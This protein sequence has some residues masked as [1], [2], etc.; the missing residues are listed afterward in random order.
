MSSSDRSSVS[1]TLGRGGPLRGQVLGER[2]EI[3]AQLRHDVYSLGLLAFDQET[4]SRVVLRVLRPQILEHGRSRAFHALRKSVGIG[5]RYLPGLLDADLDGELLFAVEPVPEGAPLRDVLDARIAAQRP[6]RAEELLVLVGHLEAALSAIPPPLRHGDVRADHVWVDP[7]RLRLMGSFLVPCL[8]QP[9]VSHLLQNDSGVRRRTAPEALRGS[10]SDAADRF[11]IGAIVCEALTLET[12]PAAG[13]TGNLPPTPVGEEVRRLL[14]ADPAHRP[15]SLDPLLD[16]L[17]RESG[18]AVPDLDPAPMRAARRMS[19]PRADSFAPVGGST[20]LRS[21]PSS[22]PPIS[23]AAKA[24][25]SVPAARGGSL[26][27]AE[28]SAA[29]SGSDDVETTNGSDAS[30]DFAFDA[31]TAVE[32]RPVAP[33]ARLEDDRLPPGPE[34]SQEASTRRISVTTLDVSTTSPVTPISKRRAAKVLEDASNR[35]EDSAAETAGPQRKRKGRMD[36]EA[37]SND[38]SSVEFED[39]RTPSSERAGAHGLDPRFVRAALTRE[40]QKPSADDADSDSDVERDPSVAVMPKTDGTQELRLDDLELAQDSEPPLD[41]SVSAT[42]DEN[43]TQQVR[44]YELEPADDVVYGDGETDAHGVDAHGV[45]AHGVDAHGVDAH[46]V[47]A[48]GVDA[49]G[50]DAHGVDAHG[51]DAHGIEAHGVDAHGVDAH[52]I[53]ALGEDFVEPDPAIPV[54]P[55]ADG[56]QELRMEDLELHMQGGEQMAMHA[57][58][59]PARDVTLD[60]L[61]QMRS[62]QEAL[63]AHRPSGG[64]H[65]NPGW[66][67][68][69]PA[70]TAPLHGIQAIP[71][72]RQDSLVGARGPI[73]FDDSGTAPP[74]SSSNPHGGTHPDESLSATN[75][76]GPYSHPTPPSQLRA[77]QVSAHSTTHGR[78]RSAAIILAALLLGAAFILGS[79]A[80]S[81]YRMQQTEEQRQQH[82]Q[83]R[84]D[85]LRTQSASEGD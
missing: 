10:P 53:D 72:P 46:G 41:P 62:R 71:R 23:R 18:L 42:A 36:T 43:G 80:Y 1:Q 21:R 19:V 6:M 15:G 82:L 31:K 68:A 35:G 2:Y 57:P 66:D 81:R 75:A 76:P 64:S 55:K 11:G 83:E 58:H 13:Q 63:R 33:R 4:E 37:G 26:S 70:A 73:L 52:G 67:D 14:C 28:D 40:A 34:I 16:A 3:R 74:S 50:V 61:E 60:D 8:P 12:P 9:V 79:I 56:T 84:Y 45:D 44:M 54:Q 20:A 51:I 38:A 49:H 24:R 78:Y 5:G 25:L 39:S 69:Q 85:R 22:L 27:A 77:V 47:D 65:G 7:H 48:H 32:S 29:G 17:S 30:E 59:A